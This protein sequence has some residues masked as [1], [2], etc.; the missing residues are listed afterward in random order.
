MVDS[1]NPNPGHRGLVPDPPT[2]TQIEKP[3]CC[4]TC[5]FYA[6]EQLKCENGEALPFEELP[7][8]INFVCQNWADTAKIMIVGADELGD[9]RFVL[10]ADTNKPLKF[11]CQEDAVAYIDGLS[12]DERISL[13]DYKFVKVIN[14]K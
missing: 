7:E 14:K 10:C 11:D 5:I 6:P 1:I 9:N 12:D 3:R 4:G 13:P 8:A 2:V